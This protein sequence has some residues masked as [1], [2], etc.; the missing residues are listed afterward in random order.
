MA[1]KRSATEAPGRRAD[2][3]RTMLEARRR[4]LARDVQGRIREAR[5]EHTSPRKAVDQ[6][7]VSELDTQDEIGFAVLQMKA[8][9][10]GRIEAA[11]R[12]LDE[13]AYGYCFQCGEEI[14]QARLRA[15]PFAVRCKECEE[16]LETSDERGRHVAPRSASIELVDGWR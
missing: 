3:L 2:E 4:E 7:D 11:L 12:R 9:T 15:L 1:T 5:G 13:G 16:A 14:A 6:G 10:L 8:D